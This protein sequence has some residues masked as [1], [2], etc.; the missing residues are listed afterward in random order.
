[1]GETIDSWDL[2][3]SLEAIDDHELFRDVA[4][5]LPEQLWAQHNYYELRP[6]QRLIFG[7]ERFGEI[8]KHR[9]RYFFPDHR[10]AWLIYDDDFVAPGPCSPRSATRCTNSG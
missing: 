10:P 5:A 6:D 7:W 3:E 1:M 2:L 4:A 9:R 8:L